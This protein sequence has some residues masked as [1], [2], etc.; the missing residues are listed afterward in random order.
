MD[1]QVSLL[2][3]G[4]VDGLGI[5]RV[6]CV[7]VDLIILILRLHIDRLVVRICKANSDSGS[8]GDNF[9]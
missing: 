5:G 9:R 7:R 8:D 2:I 3:I 6:C 1:V 4:L